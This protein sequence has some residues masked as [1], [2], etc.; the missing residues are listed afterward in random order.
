MYHDYFGKTNNLLRIVIKVDI[1]IS[2]QNSV[3]NENGIIS[4]SLN[5]RSLIS[6]RSERTSWWTRR[7]TSGRTA[8]QKPDRARAEKVWLR[9]VSLYQHRRSFDS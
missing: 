3:Y 8:F 2:N 9:Q 4:V 1:I 5:L 7:Q 6:R